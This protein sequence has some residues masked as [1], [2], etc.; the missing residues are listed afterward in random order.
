M[1]DP[2]TVLKAMFKWEHPVCPASVCLILVQELIL[3]KWMS[4][5]LSVYCGLYPLGGVVTR[6][7]TDIDQ[8]L[9]F[10]F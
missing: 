1:P 5:T 4:A 2:Q 10:N 8:R 6:A 3:R 9:P 7:C